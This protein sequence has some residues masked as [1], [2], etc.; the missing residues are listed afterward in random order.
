MEEFCDDGQFCESVG[1]MTAIVETPAGEEDPSRV[2]R[3][4]LVERGRP[5]PCLTTSVP[6]PSHV[7][8]YASVAAVQLVRLQIGALP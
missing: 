6:P 4:L 1:G 2:S 5:G 3:M 8:R 7:G